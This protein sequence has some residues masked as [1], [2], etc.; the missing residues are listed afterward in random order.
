MSPEDPCAIL[1][2]LQK[3]RR[4]IAMGKN[5]TRVSFRSGDLERDVRFDRANLAALD[6]EIRRYSRLCAE[7]KG[8]TYS[9]RNVV[10]AR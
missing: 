10:L 7:S 1:A 6:E 3:A 2:E 8:E 9:A 4:D 5:A